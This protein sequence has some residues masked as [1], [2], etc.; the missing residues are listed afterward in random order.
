MTG[1]WGVSGE[2]SNGDSIV[3]LSEIQFSSESPLLPSPFSPQIH[4]H[5]ERIH[6]S[7]LQ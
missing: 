2:G 4:C 7:H 1:F 3:I 6:L 5:P